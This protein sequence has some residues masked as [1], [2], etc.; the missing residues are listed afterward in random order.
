MKLWHIKFPFSIVRPEETDSIPSF[1][2]RD[3]LTRTVHAV[4]S[5]MPL[6]SNSI[7]GPPSECVT[8]KSLFEYLHSDRLKTL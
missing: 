5:S 8:L 4:I 7:P 2:L 1:V 3:S 6:L